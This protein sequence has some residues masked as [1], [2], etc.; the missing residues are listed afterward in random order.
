MNL[1]STLETAKVRCVEKVSA[2]RMGLYQCSRDA[3]F[4]PNAAYCKQHAA[5]HER[6]VGTIPLWKISNGRHE[7]SGL[8][9]KIMARSVTD[10]T[11]VD[12]GG[13]RNS[14]STDWYAFFKTEAEALSAL[15][16]KAVTR[17]AAG[18]RLVEET[19]K[20]LAKIIERRKEI[21][22]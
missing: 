19:E 22:A 15:E 4:G 13:C 8:P 17:N 10:K 5:K 11:F 9:V 14:I 7:T 18:K 6:E 3:G 1:R 16:K 12:E 20:W 2:G 21:D